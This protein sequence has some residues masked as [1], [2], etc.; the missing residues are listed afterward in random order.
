[1]ARKSKGPRYWP[2][3]NQWV[4]DIR[5]KRH[6]LGPDEAEAKREWHRLMSE[7][8]SNVVRSE[9]VVAMFD[10]FLEWTKRNREF[11]TFDW[12]VQRLSEFARTIPS[13]RI[14]DLKPFHVQRWID[15]KKSNG[16]K[17]GCVI[18]VNRALNWAAKQGLIDRNPISGMEKPAPGRRDVIVTEAA[19]REMLELQADQEFRDLLTFCWETGV[20]PQEAFALEVRHLDL[21]HNR[22]VFPENESKGKRKK[23]VIYLTATARQIVLRLT[24]VHPSGPLLRNTDGARWGRNN[25]AC[26]FARIRQRMGGK[27]RLAKTQISALAAELKRRQP[28]K[29]VNGVEIQKTST[30]LRREARRKLRAKL[31]T[32]QRYCLYHFRHTWMT[33]MLKAGV[34]PI[35]VATLA[36]HNDVTMLARIYAH[37]QN[38]TEHLQKALKRIELHP[39]LELSGL[40]DAT[41]Q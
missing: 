25:A 39:V 15:T 2:P 32:G 24:K 1:M 6:Y 7:R 22:C 31:A 23:R 12:Y 16:H 3:R 40:P 17:R 34:D 30:D 11:R 14:R 10:E 36:G 28:T 5:G 4:V 18:A 20:R 8:E 9:H 13:L 29:V 27:I 38:D 35:T 19:Y 37:I 41:G 21:A 33:R 26:R